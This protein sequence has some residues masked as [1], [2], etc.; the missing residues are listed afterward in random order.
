MQRL[1]LALI[2]V[3]ISSTGCRVIQGMKIEGLMNVLPHLS[4]PLN[5]SLE[6]NGVTPMAVEGH[7]R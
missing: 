7:E 6:L 4:F 5:L 2:L 3:A 1:T